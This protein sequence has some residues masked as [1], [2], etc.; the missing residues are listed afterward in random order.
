MQQGAVEVLCRLVITKG[1]ISVRWGRFVD[2]QGRA[3]REGAM[4]HNAEEQAAEDKLL[5]TYLNNGKI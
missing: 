1:V 4:Q 2:I 5:C 3:P